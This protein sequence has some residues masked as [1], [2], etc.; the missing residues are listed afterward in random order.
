MDHKENLFATAISTVV[1]LSLALSINYFLP[2]PSQDDLLW[3]I[4]AVLLISTTTRW[5]AKK[6]YRQYV[7]KRPAE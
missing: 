4:G 2:P 3:L 5:A 7:L 6:V 1:L